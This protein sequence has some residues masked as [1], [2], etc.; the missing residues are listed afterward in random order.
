MEKV[1]DLKD[2]YKAWQEE[3]QEF[4]DGGKRSMPKR[5]K[6]KLAAYKNKKARKNENV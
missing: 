5:W 4:K 3:D 6:L 1:M 2:A